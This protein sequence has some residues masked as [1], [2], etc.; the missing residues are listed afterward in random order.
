MKYTFFNLYNTYIMHVCYSYYENTKKSLHAC[1]QRVAFY[2]VIIMYHGKLVF[3]YN[4]QTV[5]QL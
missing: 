1:M 2:S 5:K 3:L 4:G